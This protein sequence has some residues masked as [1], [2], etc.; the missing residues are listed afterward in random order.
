MYVA[1]L[2]D[3]PEGVYRTSKK[4]RA[5]IIRESGVSGEY[6]AVEWDR[7]AIEDAL[8]IIKAHP[9]RH[10]LTSLPIAFRSMMNPMFSILY[11]YV[12]YLFIMG[13]WRSIVNREWVLATLFASPLAL[14]GFNVLVTHGLPRYSEQAAPLLMLGAVVGYCLKSRTPKS[15]LY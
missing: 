6:A 9:V 8:G 7:L 11:I 10:L 15:T 4:R 1:L 3:A 2:R 5:E 12:Y 14:F 13:V